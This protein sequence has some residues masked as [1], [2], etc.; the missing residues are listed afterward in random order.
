MKSSKNIFLHLVRQQM[1]QVWGWLDLES[2]EFIYL[3]IILVI[4]K[5]YFEWAQL[6][7]LFFDWRLPG[8][9]RKL[10]WKGQNDIRVSYQFALISVC[11]LKHRYASL[12]IIFI[13]W[14]CSPEM[15]P[16]NFLSAPSNEKRKKSREQVSSSAGADLALCVSPL[17]SSISF[18]PSFCSF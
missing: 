17:S 2:L 14:K 6:K 9:N 4:I 11:V 5:Y 15:F 10:R 8:P 18:F 16:F 7:C 12:N 13:R 3:E 1:F